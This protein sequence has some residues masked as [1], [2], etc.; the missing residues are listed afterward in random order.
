MPDTVNIPAQGGYVYHE[1]Y[2]NFGYDNNN[3][4]NNS[5]SWFKANHPDWLM[6]QN[7]RTSLVFANSAS[8]TNQREPALDYANPAV[9]QFIF[10][11]YILP[12][13]AHGFN[14]I[15]LDNN[16]S[17]NTFG[18]AGHY[19]LN[20]NWVQEYTGSRSDSTYTNAMAQA[21]HYFVTQAKA[22]YPNATF[23]VNDGLDC[24]YDTSLWNA[25]VNQADIVFDEQ[26]FERPNNYVSTT[27]PVNTNCPSNP[28]LTKVQAYVNFQKSTGKGIVLNWYPAYTMTPNMTVTSSQARFD[29]QWNL[30]NYLLIK[31]NHTY[32]DASQGTHALQWQP[33]YGAQVGSP[34]GD[35][36]ASQG[37]YMRTY[38]NGLAVV[39]PDGINSH[40]VTFPT[41]TYQDLYGNAVT[42]YTMSPHS[43]LVLVKVGHDHRYSGSG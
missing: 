9:Q 35:Y 24:G 12:P 17:E 40:T 36:Y 2:I 1:Y 19:D 32:L 10:N 4:W 29:V 38:T 31:Y 11:N 28:W 33:E 43:G 22:A 39:N 23:T 18:M 14:G 25:P 41:G 27:W 15:S 3:W 30:A 7:D 37:V 21:I 5:V 26:G 13:L 16:P 6:Y 20:G 8:Q 42:T 34:V